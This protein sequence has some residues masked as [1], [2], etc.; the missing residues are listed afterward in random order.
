MLEH[1]PES[2]VRSSFMGCF[3]D[4]LT[5]RDTVEWLVERIESNGPPILHCVVNAGK[6]VQCRSNPRLREAVNAADVISADG[7]AIVWFGRL[8]GIPIPERVA[9][10]DLMTDLLAEADRHGWRVFLW[11][12]TADVAATAALRIREQYP[13]IAALNSRCGYYPEADED[14]IC[15]EIRDWHPDIVFLGMSS[16]KKELVARR[17][18]RNLG[19]RL[20]MGVGG[21]FDVWAGLTRRAPVLWQRLG[22]EWLYRLRQEPGRLWKRYMFGNL[23]FLYLW[24]LWMQEGKPANWERP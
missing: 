15:A 7:Q 16:P 19:A 22:I 1:L 8:A 21:S 11:G 5:K 2:A 23:C 18:L 10:I 13:S 6:I 9:G 24:M 4:C 20:V 3:V 12:G 14:Q 17:H